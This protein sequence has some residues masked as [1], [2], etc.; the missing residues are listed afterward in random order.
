MWKRVIEGIQY[1][2]AE[3]LLLRGRVARMAHRTTAH[4]EPQFDL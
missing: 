3:D 2:L 4:H 1:P